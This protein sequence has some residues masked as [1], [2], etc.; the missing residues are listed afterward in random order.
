MTEQEMRDREKVASLMLRLSIPTGHGD[1]IDD[2]LA[3]LEA[4]ISDRYHMGE[5]A[6]RACW[7]IRQKDGEAVHQEALKRI[8]M[9]MEAEKGTPDGQELDLLVT[10]AQFYERLE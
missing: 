10:V 5:L 8:E 2:L 4:E 6:E 3:T 7:I 9:L 1:T